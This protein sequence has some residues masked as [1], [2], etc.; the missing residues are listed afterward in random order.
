MKNFVLRILALTLLIITLISFPLWLNERAFPLIPVLDFLPRIPA[1]VDMINPILLMGLC[2]GLL[3]RPQFKWLQLATLCW[4]GYLMLTDWTRVQPWSW[5]FFW[6]LA[7][8]R[9][10]PFSRPKGTEQ[11][12]DAFTAIKLLLAAYYIWS[13]LHKFNPAFINETLPWFI[14]AFVSDL[15]PAIE[16]FLGAFI[17]A[18]EVLAGIGLLIPAVVLP[19]RYLVV[20][21]HLFILLCLGPIGHSWNATV[22]PWNIAMMV[23]VWVLFKEER[24][25]VKKQAGKSAAGKPPVWKQWLRIPGPEVE[26][27]PR[28]PLLRPSKFHTL[29]IVLFWIMPGLH[30]LGKWDAYLSVSLYSGRAAYSDFYLRG[31]LPAKMNAELR[32]YMRRTVDGYVIPTGEWA[33]GIMNSP[34]YPAPRTFH[35]LARE[36]CKLAKPG[37][38]RYYIFQMKGWKWDTTCYICSE[39]REREPCRTLY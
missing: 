32:P 38:F 34:Y 37:E 26:A 18:V 22:W 30:T 4:L 20:F 14:S 11:S 16:Q 35:R 31:N 29:V 36:F 6:I 24:P 12:F 1:P 13:G 15:P 21:T 10:L 9:F 33:M 19:A 25:A 23:W 7:M 17:P 8:I 2:L 39:K 28:K 3:I 27:M 5:Q